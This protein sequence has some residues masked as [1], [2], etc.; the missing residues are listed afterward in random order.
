MCT[1]SVS[2]SFAVLFNVYAACLN[3]FLFDDYL[4]WGL[5]LVWMYC[6]DGNVVWLQCSDGN[7]VW[8]YCSNDYIVW[9]HSP[10]GDVFPDPLFDLLL[11]L[12]TSHGPESDAANDGSHLT[13]VACACLL[14]LVVVRGDTGKLLSATAA[15][16]MCPRAL[17]SQNIH[18]RLDSRNSD[19]FLHS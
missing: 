9:L 1:L 11:D 13:A 15:L 7:M 5:D 19:L 3:F 17:A 4:S 2:T 18:V 16:L 10:D 6:S 12:A 14:S 8:L